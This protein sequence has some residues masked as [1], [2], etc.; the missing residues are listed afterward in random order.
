MAC[1]LSLSWSSS[2]PEKEWGADLWHNM[3]NLETFILSEKG[4]LVILQATYCIILLIWNVQD[5]QIYR[6]K[7]RLVN[8]RDWAEGEVG[9]IAEWILG[10]LLNISKGLESGGGGTALWMC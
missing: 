1:G 8:A 5:R 7:N 3:N 6:E 10:F 9:V 4:S 2:G